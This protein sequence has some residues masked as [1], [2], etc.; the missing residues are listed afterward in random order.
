[1]C[2][3]VAMIKTL[4]AQITE[5][6]R[7]IATAIREHPH[8]AVFTSLFKETLLITAAEATSWPRS[9]TAG[10]AT[11]PATRSPATPARPRS[12]LSQANA[13][14]RAFAGGATSACAQRSARWRTAPATGTPGPKTS[15]PPPAPEATTTPARY[16]PSGVPGAGSY[17]AAGKIE[18]HMTP[19]VTAP[20]SNTSQS[21]SPP[22]RAPCPTS[23]PPSG[24]PAPLSPEGRPA[25]PSAQRLTASQHPLNRHRSTRQTPARG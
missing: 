17:G 23:L 20:C 14:Q 3:L 16:V 11:R 19:L 4:N 5:L 13:R 22:R 15:T 6:E 21:P 8:G 1:M 12:R 24:W 10:G 25:G 18:C 2:G 7:Q 9:A